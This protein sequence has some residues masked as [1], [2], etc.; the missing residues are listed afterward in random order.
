MRDSVQFFFFFG[1][2]FFSFLF[3]IN[4]VPIFILS[5]SDAYYIHEIACLCVWNCF[6]VIFLFNRIYIYI[7]MYTQDT[8]IE[9]DLCY[10]CRI[11]PFSKC[12]RVMFIV[13]THKT[14]PAPHRIVQSR[15]KTSVNNNIRR[16][17]CP[18]CL[19]SAI[20]VSYVRPPFR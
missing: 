9:K 14:V 7:C 15:L 17:R 4:E 6:T 5:I 3:S 19:P 1:I 20:A 8:R 2:F 13:L 12:L 11:N 16:A 10:V 18:V